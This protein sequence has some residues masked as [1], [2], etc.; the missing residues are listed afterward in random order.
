MTTIFH[1]G[2][3][4]KTKDALFISYL[5]QNA[6]ETLTNLSKKTKIPV[7]TLHDRLRYNQDAYINKHTTL[8]NFNKL[9]FSTLVK[10]FIKLEKDSRMQF[11]EFITKHEAVNSLY[12]INNG[13]DYMMDLIFSNMDELEAFLDQ[14][15]DRFNIQDK[16]MHF[17]IREEFREKFLTNPA[18]LP[19]DLA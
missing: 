7:S 2:I 14:I 12:R 18:L 13:F 3:K 11:Q 9:G 17:V 16:K 15:E 8:L 6:R 5:R 4:I 19:R 10:F 1:G